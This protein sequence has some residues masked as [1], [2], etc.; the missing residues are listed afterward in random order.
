M[1]SGETLRTDAPIDH[2]GKGENFAPTDLLATAVA[3]CFLT[4]MGI[5]AKELDWDLLWQFQL[6]H[7]R[8]VQRSQWHRIQ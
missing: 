3:T 4:V 6:L 1:K 5:T 2:A 8:L 7:S